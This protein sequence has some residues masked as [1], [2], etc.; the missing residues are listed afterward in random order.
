MLF[1]ELALIRW[2]GSNIY[3]LSHFTNFVLL[4]SFLGIGIGFLRS[5]SQ[6]NLFPWAPFALSVL[7]L[8][9]L[10]FPAGIDS[11]GDQLIFI[12]GAPSGLPI[13]I[14]LPV[15]FV[16]V[17]GAMATIGEGVAR[18]FVQ[19]EPLEAYSL[20]IL[21]S[22]LGIGA[23]TALS[24]AGAPPIAWGVVA[25]AALFALS[26]RRPRHIQIAAA[27]A[28]LA[29][30]GV[31]STR[32]GLSWSPY[33][34]IRTATMTVSGVQVVQISANGIPHQLIVPAS[35]D[36]RIPGNLHRA[37]YDQMTRVPDNVL[38]IGSGAGH[39]TAVALADGAKHIDAVEID[40]RID[41]I[42]RELNPDQPDA[43]PRVTVHIED[44]RAFLTRTN[45]RY[46]LVILALTDSVTLLGGQGSLRLESYLFTDEAVRAAR[47]H[48]KPGGVFAEFN[49]YRERWLVDRLAA[50]LDGA[51]RQAPCV[52]SVGTQGHLALLSVSSDPGALK[53][54]SRWQPVAV[55]G[56]FATDDH[57]FPYLRKPEVPGF[58][59][60][61]LLLILL[62][63]LG[64]VR[65]SAGPLRPMLAY[66]DLFLMGAA[67]LLLE[68]K[69]VVQFALLFGTTWLVNALVF[70]GI[71]GSVYLAVQLARRVAL[72]PAPVLYVGLFV[73]LAVAWAIPQ[74]SLLR[75]DAP[76]RFVAAV[77]VA[78]T[79]IF[80]AN[81]VFAERFKEVGSSTVAFAANLVGAVVGGCL[82]YGALIT[83]YR[84]MLFLIAA[85]YIGAFA[86][87]ATRG[88]PGRMPRI[89]V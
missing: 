25:V 16:A 64:L 24:F 85:I 15:I 86:L 33:S 76:Q 44:G 12:G 71:L 77:V 41:Q 37:I 78:F 21:G 9:V 45:Q 82:E 60:L 88:T 73:S 30:L 29:V 62:L 53:C 47:D 69:N 49:Y 57:P 34:K 63:S 23:F 14:S 42:G 27:L 19:F 68:T 39:D 35:A 75:L 2:T 80:F 17:A 1:V 3:D 10:A 74:E 65:V 54:P 28:M 26:Q 46:D 13:W 38:I 52:V 36:Q 87:H 79:P 5:G 6:L 84:A 61:T 81:L 83:G 4:G 43:D 40:P 72:P 55:D 31:E 7:V 11:N 48:L 70:A 22:L 59:I 20:D 8:F 89:S 56:V 18:A 67:F 51:Y 66:G 58:Y 50:G 32:P